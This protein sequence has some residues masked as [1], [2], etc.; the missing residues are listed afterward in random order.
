[1]KVVNK[2]PNPKETAKGTKNFAWV[3]VV[4]I[5]GIK[6]INVV[7]DVNIIALNRALPAPLAATMRATPLRR[8]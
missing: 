4:K 5:K 3:L 1:M 7:S 2:I 6:P 8:A